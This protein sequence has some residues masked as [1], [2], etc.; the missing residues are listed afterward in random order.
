MTL[1]TKY[2][3]KFNQ[4]GD[5]IVEVLIAV[6][7]VS[8][9]IVGA[10]TIANKSALQIRAAQ[11]RSEA[12]KIGSSAIETIRSKPTQANALDPGY[13]YC[14]DLQTK[15]LV[16]GGNTIP[17]VNTDKDSNYNTTGGCTPASGNVTYIVFITQST[18]IPGSF[19]IHVRWDRVGGG[20]RQDITFNYRLNP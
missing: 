6:A 1:P 10:F 16:G 3:H 8:T 13:P 11:E 19:T 5:T 7:I 14:V 18:T 4:H 2:S 17:P 15:A 12:L 9:V 20:Q